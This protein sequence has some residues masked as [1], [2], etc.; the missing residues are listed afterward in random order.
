MAGEAGDPPAAGVETPDIERFV[1]GS[2][3]SADD[4]RWLWR[5]DHEF[6]IQSHR[7]VW[8]RLVIFVKRL[9]LKFLT[10]SLELQTRHNAATTR[11]LTHFALRLE[12]LE[13]QIETLSSRV[14]DLEDGGSS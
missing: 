4:W 12:R 3:R 10:P 5:G 8:G 14:A 9:L 1:D 2:T 13:R 7:G 6:P 11:L